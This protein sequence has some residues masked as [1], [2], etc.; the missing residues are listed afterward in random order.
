[1]TAHRKDSHTPEQRSYN[2]SRIRSKNT[3]LE[4]TFFDLLNVH[5]IKFQAYPKI[6]GKPDCLIQPN[7]LVFVDSDFWHGWHFCQWKQRLP[8][9]YWIEKI[10]KNIRRDKQKFRKLR[11]D[12]YVVIRIWEHTL[13]SNSTKVVKDIARLQQ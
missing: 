6:Y 13:K 10:Q 4:K 3:K 2:M 8:K 12:G 11:R 1:M 5:E 7:L 9:D